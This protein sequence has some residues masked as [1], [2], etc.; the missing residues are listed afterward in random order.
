MSAQGFLDACGFIPT[1]AGT[2][3]FVVST[4]IQGYQTPASAGA[5]NI[6][7]SYRSESADKSQWEEG[8]GAY[9]TSTGTLARTTVTANSLGTTALVN[10]SAA[11]N[12]FITALAADITGLRATG[13]VLMYPSANQGG[14]AW[15]VIDGYGNP[16]STVGTTT[17]GLQEAI[18]FAIANGQS[19][20]VFGGGPH[21]IFYGSGTTHTNT[22]IDGISSTVGMLV[23][24]YVTGAGIPSFTTIT[25]IAANSIT[26]SHAA[27]ASATVN[28][29]VTRGAGAN[30]ANYINC[31]SGIVVPPVE[32]WDCELHDVNI[33]FASTVNGPGLQFDSCMMVTW[34]HTGQLVYQPSS[35]GA[36][37]YAVLWSPNTPVPLDGITAVTGSKFYISNHAAPA[38]NGTAQAVWGFNASLGGIDTSFF[39]SVELNGTGTGSSSN[40]LYGIVL[41]GLGATSAFQQNTFD[42]TNIHIVQSAGIQLGTSSANSASCRGNKFNIG[43][44]NPS[45]A[46]SVGLDT[47]CGPDKFNIGMITN[48]QGTL[49]IGVALQSSSVGNEVYVGRIDGAT[50]QRVDTGTNNLFVI[51]GQIAPDSLQYPAIIGGYLKGVSLATVA[52]NALV[53]KL[54]YSV[55]RY[56]VREVFITGATGVLSSA[57]CGLFTLTAGGGGAIVPG[58]TSMNGIT[59]PAADNPGSAAVLALGSFGL[60]AYISTTTLYFRVTTAQ[61]SAT[62]NVYVFIQPL[63]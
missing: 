53:I 18:N 40:T 48:E 8:F 37:S 34:V 44:I 58:G 62:V 47:F 26:I 24:D 50:T 61:A 4:P 33:T 2:T 63:P 45:G 41:F 49:N 12:V 60:T 15:N 57:Q 23:G 16:V 56:R 30:L 13:Y 32:Q 59:N 17:Q 21:S 6:V 54:P 46:S 27:T 3:N 42:I 14:G 28:I 7:Y 20:R 5:Q 11:P 38:S 43:G 25:A 39:S 22:T 51:G 36:N 35:P 9:N 31:G 52:D 19:L 1:A 55:T 29:R 10:F